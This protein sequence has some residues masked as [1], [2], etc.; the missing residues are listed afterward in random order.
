MKK[1]RRDVTDYVIIRVSEYKNN[2]EIFE[3][4]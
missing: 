1:V 4:T 2:R 3:T